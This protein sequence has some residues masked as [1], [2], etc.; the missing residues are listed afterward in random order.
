[1]YCFQY[2]RVKSDVENPVRTL[3]KE[4]A[5][6]SEWTYNI[7]RCMLAIQWLSHYKEI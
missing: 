4:L 6:Y 2:W 1:M 3:T 5:I 7:Y